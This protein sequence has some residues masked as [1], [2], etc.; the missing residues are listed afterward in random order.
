[1]VEIYRIL[2]SPA[3]LEWCLDCELAGKNFCVSSHSCLSP[4][5][6]AGDLKHRVAAEVIPCS[7]CSVLLAELGW[8][9]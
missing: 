9:L 4:G 6:V 1:M 7:L 2:C 3:K 5:A 8:V